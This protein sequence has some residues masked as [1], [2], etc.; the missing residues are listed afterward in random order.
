MVMII[1]S[2]IIVL[3]VEVKLFPLVSS[4][5]ARP[6]KKFISYVQIQLLI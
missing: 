6:P 2:S 5:C 1:S 3:Q 4:L